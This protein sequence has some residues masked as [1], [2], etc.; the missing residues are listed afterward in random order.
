MRIVQ[1]RTPEEMQKKLR[2]EIESSFDSQSEL[3]KYMEEYLDESVL[4]C[5]TIEETARPIYINPDKALKKYL[6]EYGF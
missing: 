2:K 1:V 3:D 4:P 5:L 6:E